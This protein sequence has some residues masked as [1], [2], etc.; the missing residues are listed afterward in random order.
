LRPAALDPI[1]NLRARRSKRRQIF[2]EQRKTNRKHPNA[3]HR[4]ESQQ[5]TADQQHAR[6][7][8]DPAALRLQQVGHCAANTL[9]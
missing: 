1:Q 5:A 4:Q 2:G 7:D 6:G 9:R 3:E 8:P